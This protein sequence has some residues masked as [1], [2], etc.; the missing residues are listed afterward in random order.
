[1]AWKKRKHFWE[2]VLVATGFILLISGVFGCGNTSV[3]EA[4]TVE[5]VSRVWPSDDSSEQKEEQ[6][7]EKDIKKITE[8]CLELYE[9]AVKEN[10][11][12]NQETIRSIVNRFGESGYPA[13]DSRNQIDM[14][15]A[16]QVVRFC[17]MVKTQKKAEITIIVVDYLGGFTVYELQTKTGDVEVVKSRYTYEDGKMQR[18]VGGSYQAENWKYT[19]EGYLMFSGVWFSEELYVLTL[20]GAEEYTAIRVQPLDETCR[21]LNQK[22]LLPIGYERNN[23]FLTD[24]K[25]ED[26][27]DLNFYDMYDV[28]YPKVNVR[29][30]P[31]TIDENLGVGAVYRIPKEDFERV[32]MT[33]F[34][35]DKKVLQ[36]KTVYDSGDLTYVYKPRGFYEGEYPEHPYPEVVGFTE[37]RDG[38]ISLTVHVV[39]PYTGDSKVYAHEVVVR[40]L[41]NGGVQYVSNRILPAKDN[42][43]ATWHTPRL[44]EEEWEA[45]YVHIPSASQPYVDSRGFFCEKSVR[46]SDYIRW[47]V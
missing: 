39:F 8:V 16:G 31:Y 17:K 12:D 20:S 46:L 30:V 18:E 41:E 13:V 9:K 15:R 32:I 29:D 33:Y 47:Q 26:F 24:W 43:E 42:G 4:Q 3:K 36:S 27:G 2:S 34:N 5:T 10:K 38:T 21:E 28:F 45:Y 25:E 19:K 44:T 6:H 14:V 40:P 35:I 7:T 1:M 11:T 23:M 37:N 22:Y